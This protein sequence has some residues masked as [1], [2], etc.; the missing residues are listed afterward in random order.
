M[1]KIILLMFVCLV[2]AIVTGSASADIYR[3]VDTDGNVHYTDVQPADA[4]SEQIDVKPINATDEGRTASADTSTAA[5]DANLTAAAKYPKVELFVTS[6]CG[7]CKRAE[8][9]LR[10]KGVPFTV[11]D[12]E[13]DLQ[14]ARRKDSL[15]SRK[16]VPFALIGDQRLV[17]FSELYYE[18]ALQQEQ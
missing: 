12:I 3:Y 16:G 18:R 1:Q 14:A 4:S 2:V 8:A 17:G 5:A 11:Y 9:Y 7:Y 13:K 15:A 6:W 10:K